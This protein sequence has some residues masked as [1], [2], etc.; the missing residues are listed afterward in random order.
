MKKTVTLLTVL[1][2]ASIAPCF[3][4]YKIDVTTKPGFSEGLSKVVIVTVVCHERL[5]CR[6]IERKIGT[7]IPSIAS[8]LL[9]VPVD[10]VGQALLELGK[11]KYDPSLREQLL[12]KFA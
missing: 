5:D 6:D 10:Q 12:S 2:L 4:G 1:A 8:K 3:A 9:V 7:K 11:T